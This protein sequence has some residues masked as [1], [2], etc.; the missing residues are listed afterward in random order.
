VLKISSDDA[1]NVMG[2]TGMEGGKGREEGREGGRKERKEG[3]RKR[4]V[5]KEE[6]RDNGWCVLLSTAFLNI[7]HFSSNSVQ[8][9]MVTFV[10]S[11]FRCCCCDVYE[12]IVNVFLCI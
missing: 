4:E 10:I 12:F 6:G 8:V 3:M 11:F 5:R 9:I 2:N 1:V 7:W